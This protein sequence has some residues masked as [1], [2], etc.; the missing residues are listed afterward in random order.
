M[1][2][3]SVP[4]MSAAMT[5][6]AL[7]TACVIALVIALTTALT[8]LL[9]APA[10]AQIPL[11]GTQPG[12]LTN[13]PLN[14][15]SFCQLCHSQFVPTEDY[16]PWDSWSGSMMANASRDPLFW[17]AVDIANQDN[18]GTGEWCIRCHSPRAWLEG[19]SSAPDGSL[20]IGSPDAPG[21]DFEGVDCHVCHRMYEGPTGTPYL[22]NAQFWIDDGTPSTA[23]PMRGPYDDAMAAHTTQYSPY[24]E[25]S[26]MCAVCHNVTN[27]LVNL[28]DEL[29]ADTGLQF[30][31][32][33]TYTE[34]KNSSFPAQGTQCQDCHMASTSGYACT[35]LWPLRDHLPQHELTGA[36]VF[37]STVL[38]GLC[39]DALN[40]NSN[41]DR[42]INLALDNLQNHSA[43]LWLGAPFRMAAGDTT[44]LRVR[45]TNRTGHKLPTG[46]PEGR[47]MWV[48]LR[49]E[50]GFGAVLFESGA[51][52][53]GTA[54]LLPDPDLKVY[55]AKHGVHGEGEGFHLIR[56]DRI[57]KDNR[58]PPAGFQPV[59][60]TEPVGAVYPVQPDGSLANWDVSEYTLPV[61]AAAYGPLTVTAS[62]YY[63][64]A[65]REYIEFLRDENT[66]GPDPHDPDSLAADRGTKM[67]NYWNDYGQSAPVLMGTRVKTVTLDRPLPTEA[68][69]PDPVVPRIVSLGNNPFRDRTDITFQVPP[70]PSVRVEVFEVSGRRVRTLLDQARAA[71]EHRVTWDG[72]TDA[73]GAA[74]TGS[75]FVRLDVPGHSPVVKRLLLLR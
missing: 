48:H 51:Y 70:A 67:W 75:Y 29:G 27:P 7:I 25:S 20:F 15:P 23:P 5:P 66:S 42:T 28:K 32:Q 43:D 53:L 71:G 72:R 52:D 24:H 58:I 9:P 44:T 62:L 40:R 68:V 54:T 3:T 17:A 8:A 56:N 57:F 37:M 33:M 38:K 50:D 6:A 41:F 22:E 16:E 30:P 55:E 26:E 63:Q 64:T 47:R 1:R 13:W 36:N 11:P 74:A 46:Y 21:G 65:S 45:V 12:D 39:G 2:R 73:G 59:P 31:E 34:W 61:S 60:G 4:S 35:D 19:R 69:A 49:V 18:P 10:S 14:E